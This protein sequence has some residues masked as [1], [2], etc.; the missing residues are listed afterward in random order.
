MEALNNPS[1]SFEINTQRILAQLAE[2]LPENVDYEQKDKTDIANIKLNGILEVLNENTDS[3][4]SANTKRAFNDSTG[5]PL[6][7]REM[8]EL[9]QSQIA[10]AVGLLISMGVQSDL[11]QNFIDAYI[12]KNI[13]TPRI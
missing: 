8:N 5:I 3:F 12:F 4:F 13:Q 11:A 1:G 7:Q 9:L 2:T 6:K 10:N